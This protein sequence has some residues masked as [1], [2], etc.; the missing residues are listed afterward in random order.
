MTDSDQVLSCVDGYRLIP[1]KISSGIT[2]YWKFVNF[3][4]RM[5][6]N[7]D[8]QS[9]DPDSQ[10]CYLESQKYLIQVEHPGSDTVTDV[11]VTVR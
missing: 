4:Y 11:Q 6:S 10:L 3:L 9:P 2:N 7:P 1:Y 5:I 8:V